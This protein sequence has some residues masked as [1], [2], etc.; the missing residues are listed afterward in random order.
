LTHNKN[1]IQFRVSILWRFY[2]FVASNGTN[3]IEKWCQEEISEEARNMFDDILKNNSKI[4]KPIKWLWSKTLK[5]KYNRLWEFYFICDKIQH[6]IIGEFS[7]AARRATLLVGCFHK[8]KIYTPADALD[9][10]Y[11]RSRQ[12]AK[13]EGF[14][15]ERKIRMDR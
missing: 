8:D 10:A 3:Y 5:G 11:K 13:K 4:E 9:L 12:L 15:H 14:R 1:V 7:P 2:D 6:R